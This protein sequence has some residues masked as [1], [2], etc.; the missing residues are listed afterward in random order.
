VLERGRALAGLGQLAYEDGDR[1]EAIE[2][3]E[4]ALTLLA[5]GAF[6][7]PS[8]ADTLGRAYADL[9]QLDEALAIFERFAAAAAEREDVVERV[10]F[11]V[12]LANALI[13][14]GSFARA[15]EVLGSTLALVQSWGDPVA[16]ARTY[17]SQSRLHTMQGNPAAA[18]RYARRALEILELTEHTEYTARA[19]QLLAYVELDRGHPEEALELLRRSRELLPARNAIDRARFTLEEARALMQLGRTEEAAALAMET[20]GLL[21][22]GDPLEAG[23]GYC[24]LAGICVELGERDRAIELYELAIELLEGKPSRYLVDAYRGLAELLEAAGR[25]DDALEVLK[26]AVRAQS[27]AGRPLR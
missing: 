13:D 11:S 21:A 1:H 16:R 2:L 20:A 9:G 8:A 7:Y 10:R 25:N 5:D 26:K 15:D 19:H 18:S 4:E 3:L 14:S 22:G 23:R 27:E 17:W 12:L 24:V 6:A